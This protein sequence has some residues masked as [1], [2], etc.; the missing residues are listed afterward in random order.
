MQDQ[1][2]VGDDPNFYFMSALCTF[3]MGGFLTIWWGWP[4]IASGLAAAVIFCARGFWQR[5]KIRR[6]K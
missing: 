3:V 4:F 5:Q 2:R 6:R 1:E